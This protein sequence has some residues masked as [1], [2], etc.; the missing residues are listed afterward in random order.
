M[1]LGPDGFTGRFYKSCCNIKEDILADL[2]AIRNG[3]V[4]KFRLLNTA[5]ITLI[6]KKLDSSQVKN[7]LRIS[8]IHSVAKL[9][10]VVSTIYISFFIFLPLSSVY[11]FPI[12]HSSRSL[13]H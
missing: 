10:A 13:W 4:A 6:P 11:P 3:H 9:T 8:L 7:F 5:F 1:A 12:P 2:F